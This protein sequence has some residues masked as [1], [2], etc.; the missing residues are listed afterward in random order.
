[1]LLL[2]DQYMTMYRYQVP[3]FSIHKIQMK[4]WFDWILNRNN[5]DI[6]NLQMTHAIIVAQTKLIISEDIP[7]A[8]N[9]DQSDIYIQ[10][11]YVWY[12]S[13]CIF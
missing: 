3:L 5:C 10:C 11:V 8:D 4:V 7:N 13:P 2:E 9:P 1:L 12:S 6:P